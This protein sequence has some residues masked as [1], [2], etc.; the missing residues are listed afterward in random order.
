ML[1]E[2]KAERYAEKD[3]QYSF[4][5]CFVRRVGAAG[6]LGRGGNGVVNGA[7]VR[8]GCVDDGCDWKGN[9]E[10]RSCIPSMP[11]LPFSVAARS[12]RLTL[13]PEAADAEDRRPVS[14]P[15]AAPCDWRHADGG[16][17][18]DRTFASVGCDGWVDATEGVAGSMSIASAAG[19]ACAAG[20]SVSVGTE[21]EVPLPDCV[22]FSCSLALLEGC[23]LLPGPG[24]A[25]GVKSHAESFQVSGTNFVS[26]GAEAGS[27]KVL[28]PLVDVEIGV[29]TKPGFDEFSCEREEDNDSL[30]RFKGDCLRPVGEGTANIPSRLPPVNLP[31]H[32][33]S[34]N[35]VLIV[36]SLR[37][38]LAFV[39]WNVSGLIGIVNL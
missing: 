37:L 38:L 5:D 19:P 17:A 20:C 25:D 11:A 24:E 7:K 3:A 23:C 33:D 21:P 28:V 29:G 26:A 27:L 10:F 36:S 34:E 32:S 22:L 18:Y 6:A 1:K 12:A 35:A 14:E 16:T 4:Q 39:G 8:V 13:G 31:D 2:W 9:V 30:P 15:S